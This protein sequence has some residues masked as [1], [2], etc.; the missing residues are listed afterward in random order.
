MTRRI[1]AILLLLS[2]LFLAP[3]S[4]AA[5]TSS[6]SINLDATL[7][8]SLAISSPT[9]WND[10]ATGS[11]QFIIGANSTYSSF[12]GGSLTNTGSGTSGAYLAPPQSSGSAG[13]P[14]G[15]ISVMTWVNFTSWNADWNILS[16]RWFSDTAGT[17]GP[18][19]FH[20]A[21]RKKC[22]NYRLNLFTTN[23]SDIDGSTNLSLNKWYLLGFTLGGGVP[24]FYINGQYDTPTV[25]SGVTRTPQSNAYLFVGD[26]RTACTGCSFNGYM[27]KFRMWNTVLSSS[28]VLAD[29]RNEAASLGYGTTTSLALSNN[30]PKYRIS[31]PITA[32][33]SV[34]GRITFY[35][36]GKLIPK[37]KNVVV[38]TTTGSC[39]WKPNTHGVTLIS[40]SFQPADRDFI[41]STSTQ[42]LVV[43][44][45]TTL[46]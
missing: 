28:T 27:S 13:N 14:S 32:T 7:P 6:P 4:I 17:G 44:K 40:A 9:R 34:P 22:S 39:A 12:G 3:K 15:E 10:L 36:K 46:R 23:T 20:F 2:P 45:R 25:T 37:C 42:N 26:Y 41:S 30:S 21:V 11:L 8:S 5:V 43:S 18:S 29:Y 38:A 33:V 19:D 16:S 31:N 1:I 35:E 24:K